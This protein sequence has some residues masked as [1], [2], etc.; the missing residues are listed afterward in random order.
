M[1][2]SRYALHRARLGSFGESVAALFLMRHGVQILDRNVSAGRGELDL[3]AVEA[4]TRFAVEVKTAV[5]S[6]TDHPRNHFTARK[7]RQVAALAA[8]TSLRRVDLVTVVVGS[9]GVQVDWHRRV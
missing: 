6:P 8:A 7:S 4:S 5:A 3:I 2:D 9:E 1:T